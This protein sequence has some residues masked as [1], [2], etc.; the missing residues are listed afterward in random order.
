MYFFDLVFL[1]FLSIIIYTRN[2]YKN[3]QWLERERH[4]H[5]SQN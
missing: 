5:F 2:M 3:S 4:K 1:S